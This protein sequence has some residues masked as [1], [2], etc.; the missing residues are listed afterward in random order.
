[1]GDKDK[2]EKLFV[3]CGDVFAELVN[4]LLY[5]GKGILSEEAMLPGPTES[6]SPEPGGGVFSQFQDYS[7][8]VM[9]R[10]EV[11]ALYT[12]E[13]QS[14][15]ESRMAL[16]SAGYEGAAYR[17]QYRMKEKDRTKGQGIYP[18][19]SLVLNWSEKRWTAATSVRELLDY[20]VPEEAEDYLDKNRMHVFDMRFL[21]GPVRELFQGDMRVVLDYLSDRESLLDRRQILRNPEEVLRMLYALS[22]DERYLENIAFVKE[23]GRAVCDLLDEMVNK[24]IEQGM[25]RG[26]EQGIQQGIQRG[27]QALVTTCREVGI[28]FAETAVKLREK[29]SLTPEETEGYLREYWT[30]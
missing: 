17:R 1:M 5:R 10:G 15:V 2:A 19:I 28:T 13:N 26:I 27:I 20:A 7:M 24:G 29:F 23:G 30:E 6:V 21:D 4:V 9:K 8:Y 11:L 16:R 12:L 14:S 3:A 25:Q 18:V 22:G